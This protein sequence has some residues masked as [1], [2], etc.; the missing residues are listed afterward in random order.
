MSIKRSPDLKS[1]E[2]R[3]SW[4]AEYAKYIAPETDPAAP[5]DAKRSVL[6]QFYAGGLT[7]FWSSQS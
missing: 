1:D 4:S 7:P 3:A 6:Q 5:Y 2:E